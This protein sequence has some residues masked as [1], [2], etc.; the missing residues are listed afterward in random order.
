MIKSIRMSL[1]E[2]ILNKELLQLLFDTAD[3]RF[4]EIE[5]IRA[6][7]RSQIHFITKGDALCGFYTT[8]LLN[9]STEAHAYLLPQYRQ[10]SLNVLRHI[11]NSYDSITTSVYGTHSHVLKFLQRKGFVITNTLKDALIK[12]NK[13]YDV[14]VLSFRRL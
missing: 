3:D 14:W 10:Y 4:S 8:E 6:L 7:E 13:T 9:G 12:N 1:S 5:C 2:L 11:I